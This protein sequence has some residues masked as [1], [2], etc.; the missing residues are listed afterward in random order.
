MP[1]ILHTTA[2]REPYEGFTLSVKAHHTL[3]ADEPSADIIRAKGRLPG[4]DIVSRGDVVLA[5][6]GISN[7]RPISTD[8]LFR[9]TPLIHF[10]S[11]LRAASIHSP[12]G[13]LRSP[14][15]V[16]LRMNAPWE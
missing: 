11:Y 6:A 10:H 7:G 12:P 9:S 2:V 3:I 13:M 14:T 15:L 8:E 4:I 5:F 16:A 1:T